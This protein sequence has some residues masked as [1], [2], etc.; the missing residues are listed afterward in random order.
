[1]HESTTVNIRDLRHAK[2]IHLLSLYTPFVTQ[3]KIPKRTDFQ[4][5]NPTIIPKVR[6]KHEPTQDYGR[7]AT[8]KKRHRRTAKKLSL[9]Y[10]WDIFLLLVFFL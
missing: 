9:Q 4:V 10:F 7:V 5:K 3:Y 2:H 1:M 8:T 6:Q